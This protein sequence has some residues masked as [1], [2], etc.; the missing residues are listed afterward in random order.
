MTKE[1][2]GCRTWGRVV[3]MIYM[4][5]ADHG[6]CF[7]CASTLHSPRTPCQFMSI[8][9]TLYKLQPPV[10]REGDNNFLILFVPVAI[11]AQKLTRDRRFCCRGAL[12]HARQVLENGTVRLKSAGEVA[13]ICHK[14]FII[15]HTPFLEHFQT[16]Q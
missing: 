12:H 4:A 8:V 1:L 7:S 6:F 13:T 9:H 14:I 5:H 2:T 10:R 15:P 3:Q 16:C 11:A